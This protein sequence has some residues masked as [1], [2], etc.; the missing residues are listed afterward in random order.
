MV[1]QS[2][3]YTIFLRNTH[4]YYQHYYK[5]NN[6]SLP[7]N[8]GTH[9]NDI[10]RPNNSLQLNKN[11]QNRTHCKGVYVDISQYTINI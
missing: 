3:E 2:N 6:M 7:K 1:K 5:L 4:T 9:K 8:N 10:T 11:R